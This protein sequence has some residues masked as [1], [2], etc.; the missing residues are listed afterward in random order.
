MT[1][2]AATPPSTYVATG[3]AVP[4]NL[5][6][7]HDLLR[8]AVAAHAAVPAETVM[9]FETAVMEIAGNVVEHGRPQ[10]QVLWRFEL[11]IGP[12]SLTALLS[13]SGEEYESLLDGDMPDEWAES[14]RGLPLAA[15][16]LH[17]M[18]FRRRGGVNQWRLVR[19]YDPVT[20]EPS[21]P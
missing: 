15:A 17:E 1:G 19:N 12:A 14:G 11:T 16:T 21:A 7:L 18:K 4:E 8:S 13:D 10:G 20:S 6:E 5:D 9:M 3:L 2:E